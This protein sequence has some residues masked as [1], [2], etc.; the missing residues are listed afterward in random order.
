MAAATTSVSGYLTS[1]D[2]NT[3]NGKQPAGSYLTANQ[4]ITLSGV[5]TGSGTTAITTAFGATPWTGNGV[6]GTASGLYGTPNITVGVLTANSDSS[7]SGLAIGKGISSSTNNTLVGSSALSSLATGGANTAF[8]YQAGKSMTGGGSNVLIGYRTGDSAYSFS[9][10]TFIGDR[11]GVSN[12]SN[13][14]TGVGTFALYSLTS[15]TQNVALGGSYYGVSNGSLGSLTT[16]NFNTACGSR[17]GENLTTG[18]NNGFFGYNAQPSA[19]GV[20]NEYTYG[21]SS[22]VNHRFLSTTDATSTTAAALTTAGGL[23]VAKSAFVGGSLTVT[24]TSNILDGPAYIVGNGDPVNYTIKD[25]GGTLNLNWYGGFNVLIASAQK[26]AVNSGGIGVTG[27]VTASTKYNVGATHLEYGSS[28]S[29]VTSTPKAIA[30]YS[31]PGIY[32]VFGNDGSNFFCDLVVDIPGNTPQVM[33]SKTVIGTPSVRTYSDNGSQ[34][35]LSMLTGT[36]A[37]TV[38]SLGSY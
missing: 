12:Q 24:S 22:V 34:L 31:G 13:D 16:G 15:G 23:G 35:L 18:S 3:F 5:V 8:G 19:V 7:I 20:S 30:N 37:T 9:G 6:N 4:T 21:N 10:C 38:V 2:W 25:T 11:N 27:A 29:G 14:N 1:T 33:V 32:F 36:Y 28:T 17:A 26:L